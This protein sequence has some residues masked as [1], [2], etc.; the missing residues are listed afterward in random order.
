[1]ASL[2]AADPSTTKWPDLSGPEMPQK[3]GWARIKRDIPILTTDLREMPQKE[4]MEGVKKV[5]L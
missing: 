5:L 1:M 2:D 3:S 4:A